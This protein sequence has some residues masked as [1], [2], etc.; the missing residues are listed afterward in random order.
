MKYYNQL[1]SVIWQFVRL[2]CRCWCHH[3]TMNSPPY[4]PF[5]S[6][7]GRPWMAYS[8]GA[9]A[10]AGGGNTG[11][12]GIIAGD[13]YILWTG[14]NDM[15]SC[16]HRRRLHSII[17]SHPTFVFSYNSFAS[18]VTYVKCKNIMYVRIYQL[19]WALPP[20]ISMYI[21]CSL[22]WGH[23]CAAAALSIHD[24]LVLLGLRVSSRGRLAASLARPQSCNIMP[25]I[26][27][28]L[29]G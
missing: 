14:V 27:R 17:R 20:A 10:A 8:G 11:I 29:L 25:G 26:A 15:N 12:K 24:S 18:I 5:K 28:V 16:S 23:W 1:V 4:P 6:P 9:A 2:G 3:S 7:F 13:V 19:V 21:V 22:V